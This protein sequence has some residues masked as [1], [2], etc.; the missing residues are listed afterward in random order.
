VAVGAAGVAGTVVAVIADDADDAGDVPYELVAVT[1]KVYDTPDCR[2]A[3]TIEA[4]APV[5]VNPPGDEVTVYEVAAFLGSGVKVTVAA[6]LLYALAVPTST[7]E[8]AVGAYGAKKSFCCRDFFPILLLT[9]ILNYSPCCITN[10][11]RCLHVNQLYHYFVATHRP[12]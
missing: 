7:A 4:D 6:P 5:P 9:A 3:T 11:F 2:P 12:R 1:V 8:T 10:Y